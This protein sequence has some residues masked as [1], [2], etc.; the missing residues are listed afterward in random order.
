VP[1]DGHEDITERLLPAFFNLTE[2]EIWGV[3]KA[4]AESLWQIA[5]VLPEELRISQNLI[6]KRKQTLTKV[7][8]RFVT[9]D[10][11]KW[12][13]NT[14]FQYLG[15]FLTVMGGGCEGMTIGYE[16]GTIT[17]IEFN[18]KEIIIVNGKETD[19]SRTSKSFPFTM[20]ISFVLNSIDVIVPFSYPIVIPSHP[21]PITVKN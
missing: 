21:P 2:D 8:R 7:Y 11:S 3:R 12:V 15:Q 10:P 14:A 17:S 20:I 16:N 4:C 6:G 9:S 5:Q 18:T 1:S 13:R 19:S